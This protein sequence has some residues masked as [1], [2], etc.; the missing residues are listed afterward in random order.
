MNR[1]ELVAGLATAVTVGAGP[2]FGATGQPQELRIGYQK[3]SLL[4]IP[5]AQGVLEKRFGPAGIK[6][7][8]VEFQFGPPLLEALGSGALDYGY[9]G[10]APP[11]FAQAAH[12]N[13]VYAEVIPA[14]GDSQG[15]VVK[16][17]SAIETLADL[18]GKKVGVA[19]GSSAHDLLAAALQTAHLDWADVT[20]VYLAPADA[21]AAFTRGSIDAWSIWDPF[22]AIAELHGSARQLPL[23][24]EATSQNSYFLANKTFA[25]TYPQIV[26]TIN[27]ELEKTTL[28]VS[29]HRDEA[30]TLFSKASG[31]SLAAEKLAVS[32]A[33]Y[34]A[35]P[36]TDTIIAQQQ[37]IAD[38]FYRLGLIPEKIKVADVVWNRKA[39][40]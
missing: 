24:R 8:W 17:T 15:I 40:S 2:V 32:R 38:R 18:K 10:D 11:I 33:Q 29:A 21:F 22:L 34:R 9:A 39:G 36:L 26:R 4:L 13:I 30:A 14:R 25:N 6:V 27:E 7:T 12:A 3:S 5:K 37:A 28:W 19:K 35:G 20:P 1:R 23:D 16:K 31:V